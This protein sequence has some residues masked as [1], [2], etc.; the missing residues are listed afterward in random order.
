MKKVFKLEGL[1]CAHCATQIEEKI[2]QLAGVKSVSINFMTT[3]MSL[4]ISGDIDKI[5]EDIKIII[6]EAE[7]GVNIIK[8]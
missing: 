2:S 8:A 1:N 7:P 5:L 6:K 3:K 4:D